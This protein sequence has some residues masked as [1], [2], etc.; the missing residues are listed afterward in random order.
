MLVP[1][2][3]IAFGLALGRRITAAE[4]KAAVIADLVVLDVP[5]VAAILNVCDKT[6]YR[7]LRS[8]KLR[9]V[10]RRAKGKLRLSW[11]IPSCEVRAYLDRWVSGKV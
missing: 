4:A 1:S 10:K 6:V 3:S 2:P 9:G 7:L 8:G 11:Q 5:D